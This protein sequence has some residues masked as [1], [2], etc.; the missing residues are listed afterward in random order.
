MPEITL[1]VILT[2][3]CI[4]IHILMNNECAVCFVLIFALK[5]NMFPLYFPLFTPF[6]TASCIL[7][8]QKPVNSADP[9]Y[10]YCHV[11]GCHCGLVQVSS[12]SKRRRLGACHVQHAANTGSSSLH[13]HKNRRTRYQTGKDR[14]RKEFQHSKGKPR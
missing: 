4:T 3:T 7:K 6:L 1:H 11:E 8:S 14:I 10:D 13:T 9:W 12:C 2:A 5:Q